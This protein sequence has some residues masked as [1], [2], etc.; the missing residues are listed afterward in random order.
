MFNHQT[1][2]DTGN[3][4]VPEVAAEVIGAYMDCHPEL[5]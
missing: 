3:A 4:I 1:S 2:P 5:L